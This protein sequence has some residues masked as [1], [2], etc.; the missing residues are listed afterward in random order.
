MMSKQRDIIKELRKATVS[1]HQ[2]ERGYGAGKVFKIHNSAA[3]IDYSH[4]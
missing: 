2:S 1:A 3:I 4:I